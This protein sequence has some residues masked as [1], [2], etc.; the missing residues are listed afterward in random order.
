[1]NDCTH[2]RKLDDPCWQ[3]DGWTEDDESYGSPDSI[4]CPYCG[5]SECL[6]DL[7]TDDCLDVG[8]IETCSSCGERYE[9]ACV[10]YSVTVTLRQI[11]KEEE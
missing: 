9:I 5:Q 3:C 6:T 8:R 10:D 1:V 4:P 11:K 2:R 7:Q